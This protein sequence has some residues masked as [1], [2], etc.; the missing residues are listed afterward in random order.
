MLKQKV[1]IG[2]YTLIEKI[3]SGG[4][5]DVWKAEKRTIMDANYFALKFFRPKEDELNLEKIRKEIEVWKKVRGLPH[6]ISVIELDKFE[7]YIYVVSDFADGGSL[8]NWL[9]SNGGKAESEEH[10]V[11]IAIEIL[12]GLE[13]L[14]EKGVIHRDLKP[15]NILIMNGKHCLADFGVSREVKSQSKATGTA[16]TMEYMPPEAFENKFSVQTDIWAI[17]VILQRLLSGNIPFPQDNQ[18]ALIGAII[19]FEGEKIP[20]NISITLREI[21]EKCLQKEPS[22]RFSSV[23]KLKDELQSYLRNS[24]NKAEVIEKNDVYL[25]NILDDSFHEVNTFK[26]ENSQQIP[27]TIEAEN[28]QQTAKTEVFENP[29]LQDDENLFWQRVCE[30]NTISEY[31][32]YIWSYPKGK[33]LDACK[34]KIT[35]LEIE[36]FKRKA[37]E[38][39]ILPTEDWREIER[40]KDLE[41]EKQQEEI[42]KIQDS[43]KDNQAKPTPNYFVWVI[44][45]TLALFILVFAIPYIF[46]FSNNQQNATNQSTDKIY[47][48]SIGMEFVLIPSGT[49]MMGSPANEAEQNDDE[50]QH[51]VT[52]SKQFY[53]GKYEVTQAEWKAVMGNNPSNFKNCPKCPVERVSWEDVQEF[54]KKLNAKGEGT[55]RLPTEAEWEYAARAG[56]TTAFAFGESL[57]SNQANFNGNNPY[58][59]ATNGNATKGET[60]PVGSYYAN[61]FGLY[62]M[63]GNVWEWCNDWYGEYP[64][65]AVTDPTGPSSGS[66]RVDRG[67]G[68]FNSD[69]DLRSAN[70]GGDSPSY[71]Y[72][73]LGFRLIRNSN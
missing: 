63:H 8:E 11:K 5:G 49:F 34:D 58:G 17:G 16:G 10:A 52:I 20:E 22:K 29:I 65:S 44:G 48:N 56:T 69:R 24:V 31:N 66:N 3:G 61:A 47:K 45:A 39:S 7:D 21:V 42:R 37:K 40:K 2:E 62:D 53:M 12:T 55:Y 9:K 57:S 35:F 18:A 67:G 23:S 1:K 14:H 4:F 54:I 64:N 59:N 19:M 70:R 32:R 26:E 50:K 30:I 72:D 36:N 27:E 73:N 6:I 71:R 15:D 33:F 46:N 60:T 38:N 41:V 13:N 43:L 51:K 25:A 28:S 68:W